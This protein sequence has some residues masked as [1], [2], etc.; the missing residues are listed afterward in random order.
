MEWAKLS[1]SPL[2]QPMQ[3]TAPSFRLLSRSGMHRSGLIFM[4]S[5]RPAHS[6]HA[7]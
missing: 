2:F 6:G 5:P 7:P 3:F 4:I 1:P